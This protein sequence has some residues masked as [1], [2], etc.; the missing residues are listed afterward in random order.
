MSKQLTEEKIKAASVTIDVFLDSL[1]SAE[2]RKQQKALSK[3][4]EFLFDAQL[5]TVI[6]EVIGDE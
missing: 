1:S 3:Y 2:K 5:Q 6:G 4:I